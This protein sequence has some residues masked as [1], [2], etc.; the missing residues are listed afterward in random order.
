[1]K[2]LPKEKVAALIRQWNEYAERCV[3]RTLARQATKRA[4]TQLKGA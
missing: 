1:M 3:R 2:K 4:R